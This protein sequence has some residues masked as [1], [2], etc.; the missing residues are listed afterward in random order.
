MGKVV[1]VSLF[2]SKLCIITVHVQAVKTG[3]LGNL[4]I[5][6]IV[7]QASNLL[8]IYV[9]VQPL[10]F[11]F[12]KTL[13]IHVSNYNMYKYKIREFAITT[14]ISIFYILQKLF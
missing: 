14:I 5:L 1:L 2:P 7:P 4:E 13:R 9:Q 6:I 10:S 11:G 12:K 8:F 3:S